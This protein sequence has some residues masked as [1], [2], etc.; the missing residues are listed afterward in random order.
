MKLDGGDIVALVAL[1]SNVTI[2]VATLRYQR[3]R[4]QQDR[5]WDKRTAVYDEYLGWAVAVQKAMDD[6]MRTDDSRFADPIP[7]PYSDGGLQML[8][9]LLMFASNQVRDVSIE[10]YDAFR[11]WEQ[12]YLDW[13][14]NH[15]EE[16]EA[17]RVADLAESANLLSDKLAETIRREILTG[18]PVRLRLRP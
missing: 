1:A 12:A 9:R 5:L 6:H 16:R 2:T 8:N 14:N 13:R 11:A 17:R 4:A 3:K 7:D 15:S 18:R 10:H